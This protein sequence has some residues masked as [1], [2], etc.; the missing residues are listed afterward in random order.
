[1]GK[2]YNLPCNIAKT[3]DIIGDRWTLLIIRELMKGR[4]KFNELKEALDGI[5]PNIL[6]ERLKTLEG[7]EMVSSNLYVKHPPRFDYELT[8]KGKELKHVLNALAIW[9]NRHFEKK[10]YD[11]VHD[12]C[13][14]EMEISYFCPSCNKMTHDIRYRTH[15][16]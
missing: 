1:M 16:E 2:Q 15:H 6:S 10:Y 4:M 8:D 9:G 13:G 7:E 5:A 11:L 3:L 14:H 12:E